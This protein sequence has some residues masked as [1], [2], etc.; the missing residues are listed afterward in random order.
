MDG[1]VYYTIVANSFV[2]LVMYSYYA[3][4]V[5]GVKITWD[6]AVTALQMFQFL[7]MNAQAIYIM[8]QGC[9]YPYRVTAYYLGYIISLFALFANFFVRKHCCKARGAKP[10][11]I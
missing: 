6:F 10:K 8:T 4:K 2:H 11:A 1:D 9:A 7:T 5:L 3:L